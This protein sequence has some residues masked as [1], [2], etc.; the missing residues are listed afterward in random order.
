MRVGDLDDI[1]ELHIACFPNYFITGLGRPF[2]REFYRESL[3]DIALV[4]VVDGVIAGSQL[5]FVR[6]A[7][8]FGRM[9]AFG[10]TKFA[11]L[12]A[13]AAAR[14]PLQAVRVALGVLKPVHAWRRKGEA[15][16][17]FTAVDPRFRGR[18]V[19]RQLLKRMIADAWLRRVTVIHGENDDDPNLNRLYESIGFKKAGVTRNPF[20]PAK[21]KMMAVVND[22]AERLAGDCDYERA[23]AE[24]QSA[25]TKAPSQLPQL[26]A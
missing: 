16:A 5:T 21:V 1:V 8:T 13:P 26:T 7:K 23:L 25:M 22:S 4:A 18:G 9:L 17:M 19:A 11:R 14:G 2:L 20:G 3:N 12:A 24:A 15:I 6:P 10:G